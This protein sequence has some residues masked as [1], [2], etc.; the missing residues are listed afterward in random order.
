ME[1]VPQDCLDALRAGFQFSFWRFLRSSI[2]KIKLK[3]AD[4][5]TL[6]TI[7]TFPGCQAILND[8]FQTFDGTYQI[9]VVDLIAESSDYDPEGLFCWIPKLQCF[10][11]VDSE[12][13][14]ILTFP[15][16]AWSSI[17]RRH[18]LRGDPRRYF[19]LATYSANTKSQR[20]MSD[21]NRLALPQNWW[22][23]FSISGDVFVARFAPTSP[24]KATAAFRRSRSSPAPKHQCEQAMTGSS[25]GSSHKVFPIHCMSPLCRARAAVLPPKKHDFASH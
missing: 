2:G 12:H 9:D 10:A 8:P 25:E 6:T 23:R 13:G 24:T 17:V 21:E 7:T 5:L 19:R 3:T 18:V 16:V 20:V 11:S 4:Q 22:V 15:S 14:D 1:N